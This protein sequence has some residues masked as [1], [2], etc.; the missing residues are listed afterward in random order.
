MDYVFVDKQP[1]MRYDVINRFIEKRFPDSCTYLEI[2]VRN[3]DD[4]FNRIKA[5][6]KT[7]VDPGNEY[8]PNPV[9]Y[10][11]TSDEFFSNLKSG[12]TEFKSDKKWDV[13]FIDGL[14]IAEQCRTD[15]LNSLEHLS[16]NGVI[17]LHDC[18]PPM[19]Y[20]SH[21][22]V[23]FH[24]KNGGEWNGTIWKTVYWCRTNLTW[25]TYTIDTDWGIGIIDRSQVATTIPHEN[26]FYEFHLMSQ[27]RKKHLGLISIDEFTGMDL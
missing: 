4:C 13:I 9:Q 24:L 12:K 1:L 25:K 23:E 17:V 16:P 27:N 6:E 2:G 15:V 19:W 10:K 7:S 20:H 11:M 18:N 26:E 3:P 14:H 21:S 22:D 5:T 8:A